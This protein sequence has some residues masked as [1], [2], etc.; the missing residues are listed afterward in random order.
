MLLDQLLSGM[1]S[2]LVEISLNIKEPGSSKT[3]SSECQVTLETFRE[4][5][6]PLWKVT[7]NHATFQGRWITLNAVTCR[8][9]RRKQ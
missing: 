2:D 6:L 5:V 1:P 4:L 8:S 3:Y 9:R 7:K